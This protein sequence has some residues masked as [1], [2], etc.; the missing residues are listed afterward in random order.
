MTIGVLNI[1]DYNAI[2]PKIKLWIQICKFQLP[3]ASWILAYNFNFV[4]SLSDK[5]IRTPI[6]GIK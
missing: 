6:I 2:G 4:Q 1:Y 3:K 5:L